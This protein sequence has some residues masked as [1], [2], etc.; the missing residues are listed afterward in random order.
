MRECEFLC[1]QEVALEIA[2][3]R[4]QLWILN[5]VVAPASVSLVSNNRM[6]QPCE[7]HADLVRSSRFQLYVQQREP[8]KRTSNVIERQGV[9]TTSHHSHARAI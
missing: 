4:S 9:A 1:V 8:L 5:R 3:S 6:F 2:N 7:M